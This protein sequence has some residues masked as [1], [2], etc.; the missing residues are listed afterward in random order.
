MST[1][2]VGST[3]VPASAT[4]PS[5]LSRARGCSMKPRFGGFAATCCRAATTASSAAA[6]RKACCAHQV[7]GHYQVCGGLRR[8]WTLAPVRILSSRIS[9]G[10]T[11]SIL[12]KSS[13]HSTTVP[14]SRLASAR[15][16]SA[17]SA[18]VAACES[19]VTR[20]RSPPSCRLR[21]WPD[22]SPSP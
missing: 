15:T 3:V 11:G 10:N 9:P 4:M 13:F 14:W 7:C 17:P 22:P 18:A 5:L 8:R 2:P 6:R 1:L 20:R 21:R 19:T 12:V 16:P